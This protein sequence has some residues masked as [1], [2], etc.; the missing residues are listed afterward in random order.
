VLFEPLDKQKKDGLH[1]GW[2]DGLSV[3]DGYTNEPYNNTQSKV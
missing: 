1:D 3:E 2:M